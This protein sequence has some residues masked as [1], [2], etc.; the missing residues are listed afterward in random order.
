MRLDLR[1][2]NTVDGRAIFSHMADF[3]FTHLPNPRHPVSLQAGMGEIDRA[4]LQRLV[5][6]AAGYRHEVDNIALM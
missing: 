4:F 6:V 2:L 1:N 3:L 5:E